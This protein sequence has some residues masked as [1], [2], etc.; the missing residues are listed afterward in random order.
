VPFFIDPNPTRSFC[1]FGWLVHRREGPAM[2]AKILLVLKLLFADLLG[3]KNTV[4]SV[5][6]TNEKVEIYLLQAGFVV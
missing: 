1:V 6:K 4:Y 2:H 5:Y 3:E